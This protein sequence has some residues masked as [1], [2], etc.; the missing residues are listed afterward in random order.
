M[1]EEIKSYRIVNVR[2]G[3]YTV[4]CAPMTHRHSLPLGPE[5]VAAVYVFDALIAERMI[6]MIRRRPGSVSIKYSSN[7]TA[8]VQ[9]NGPLTM[10]KNTFG[11]HGL[12]TEVPPWLSDLLHG[13]VMERMRTM[14]AL[15][16]L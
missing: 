12:P 7:F 10:V 4:V 11:V 13:D 15:G 14:Q 5:V 8:Y 16:E 9:A 2:I 6:D 1:R 3:I